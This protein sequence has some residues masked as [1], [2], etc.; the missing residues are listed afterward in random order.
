MTS[1]QHHHC[2][3]RQ[4]VIKREC[5]NIEK[6]RRRRHQRLQVREIVS[7][8]H[9]KLNQHVVSTQW[10]VERNGK[11]YTSNVLPPRMRLRGWLVTSIGPEVR[12]GG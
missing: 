8:T 11:N 10:S 12:D 9:T 6:S 5:A 1:P 3:L 7:A 2:V 4:H